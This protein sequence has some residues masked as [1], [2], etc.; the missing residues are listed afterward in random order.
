MVTESGLCQEQRVL[1][2]AP[3]EA[4][5]TMTQSLLQEAG[6]DCTICRDLDGLCEACE[7]GVGAILLTEDVLDDRNAACLVELLEKQPAWSDLPVILLTSRGAD[8]PIAA[9]AMDLLGNV[10]LLERPVRVTTLVSAVRTALRGRRRQYE[11]RRQVEE[12]RKR[13]ERL[14]LL[15]EA[16]AVLLTSDDP[17][18]M[19]RG[20][21]SRIAPHFGLDAYFNF[22]VDET[23]EALRMESCIGIPAVEAKRI[24]RL[25]FG[26]A[27]CG[28][29][30]LRR[31]PTMATHIQESDDPKVQLVKGFGLRSYAC[32]PLMAGDRLLG[33]LSFA[34]RTRDAFDADEVE[35]FETVCQYV[36]Y[37]YERLRLIGRLQE[38]DRKKDDFLATLAHELRNPL[39]PIRNAEQFLRLKGSDDPD[40][41]NAR[42]IIERQVLQLT[43]LVDDLLDVSRITRG[44]IGLRKDR[45]SLGVVLTNA[46]EASRPIIEA[47]R[48]T[49]AIDLP[50]DPL[51]LD[52]DLTRLTQIFS[53][54]LTNAAKYTEPDGSIRLAAERQGSDVIVSVRDNGIGIAA[55]H[56]PRV[57]DM[58]SQVAP[59]LERSQGGLG[60][61]LSLVKSLVEMHGGRVEARSAGLGAGS[62]FEVRLPLL[63]ETPAATETVSARNQTKTAT[64]PPCRVLVADDNVDSA[65]SLAMMLSLKGHEVRTAF[66]GLSAVEL[67]ECFQPDLALLDIGM[68][69]LNGYDAAKLIR[70]Q[71]WG[72]QIVLAALTG[73]GQSD[74]KRR[75]DDAGFDHHFTKPVEPDALESLLSTACPK[76]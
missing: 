71:P 57:F 49:L 32:S 59:A 45:V 72:K 55:E 16:A 30:A 42:D 39:A 60:I 51:Y 20:L 4:D 7:S 1:V 40:L 6:V 58:F 43:R 68:P 52:G 65:Q 56:L 69:K 29:V 63:V 15:S 18:A 5:A 74:D 41:T 53:N 33:T 13:T 75:A 38:E 66:D 9:W 21:F 23:G 25:E 10:T 67:A 22:M 17:N 70:Q 27:I 11:L 36:T 28:W 35:F 64:R 8:S 62:E 50:T 24:S 46:V 47:Q 37:A 76:A 44:K 19:M 12:L 26:Q 61:G 73:W 14:K 54:I 31:T 34:S 3:T 48:H 2:L